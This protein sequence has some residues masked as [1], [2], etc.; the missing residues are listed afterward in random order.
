MRKMASDEKKAVRRASIK[1][2]ASQAFPKRAADQPLDSVSDEA[3]SETELDLDG[4]PAAENKAPEVQGP[5]DSDA[6]NRPPSSDSSSSDSEEE[7]EKD[8][9]TVT[10]TKTL[11]TIDALPFTR[12][13]GIT[14]VFLF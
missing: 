2:A 7:E 12:Q 3:S 11:R 6:E 9:P 14:Q 4:P 10:W 8:A 13:P 1:R 5:P